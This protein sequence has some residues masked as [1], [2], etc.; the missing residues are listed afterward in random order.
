MSV[1]SS[2]TPM[3]GPIDNFPYDQRLKKTTTLDINQIHRSVLIHIQ[4]HRKV[5]R[6]VSI[7][8]D[9]NQPHPV[10]RPTDSMSAGRKVETSPALIICTEEKK[11]LHDCRAKRPQNETPS[12]L[13]PPFTITL[14][15][16]CSHRKT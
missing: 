13:T 2:Q 12:F 1:H 6:N 8:Y 16:P 5:L 15:G 10:I 7:C 9:L 14:P 4:K 11:I 3:T